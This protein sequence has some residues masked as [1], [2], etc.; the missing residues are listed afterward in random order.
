MVNKK[1]LIINRKQFGYHIDTFYYCRYLKNNYNI[2]Y[3]CWDEGLEKISE[4]KICIKYLERRGNI[5]FRLFNFLK[6]SLQEISRFSLDTDIV[7]VKYFQYCFLLPLIS[8]K[9]TIILDIR[10]GAIENKLFYRILK[11]K[12]LLFESLF[13]NY[14]SVISQSLA[15]RLSIS[16]KNPLILPL[17]A[18]SNYCSK[19]GS[20]NLNLIY[21]GTFSNRNIHLT[22]D[23]IAKYLR[24]KKKEKEIENYFIIGTGGDA[25]IRRINNSIKKY[26][27]THLIKMLGYVPNYKL[28]KYFENSNLGVSFI[29]KTKYFNCQP[30][31]KTYEYL[32][33]GLP[34][35]ATNTSENVKIIN[36]TNGVLID[37]TTDSFCNGLLEIT[38][39]EFNPI[40]I[41]N[42]AL[43]FTWEYIVHYKLEPFLKSLTENNK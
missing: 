41:K 8:K 6:L 9:K 34:V 32:L 2:T 38:K 3:L 11:D 16:F 30:P 43:K 40:K 20:N 21:V 25:D 39:K 33:G 29:P 18:E 36:S 22:I 17:G 24:S 37:D 42:N 5:F 10:T 12:L 31:T 26:K 15:S 7:F 14:I 35:I 4:S 28:K 13:F 1:L 23:G 27:L 19:I